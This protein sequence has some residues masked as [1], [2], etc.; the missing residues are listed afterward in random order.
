MNSEAVHRFLEETIKTGPTGCAL[1]VSRA[2]TVLYRGFHGFMDRE[3]Q[4]PVTPDTIYRIYS[5]TK[6]ITCTAAMMLYERGAFLLDE[7]LYNYLPEYREMQVCQY[8]SAQSMHL[9]PAKMPIRIR[10]LFCMTSGFTYYGE[11]SETQR[12][13]AKVYADCK[14]QR[15]NL[16]ET[17]RRL[18][19][20]PLAFEPGSRWYYGV[21]HDILGALIEVL[22][23]KTLAQ[24][25]Q[26][27]I[28]T[29]LGMENT[30]F[31][32]PAEK[33]Q[34]L[35]GMYETQPDGSL[36]PHTT[37]HDYY[38]EKDV[39][40][41]GG[42]GL[43]STL[44]DYTRFTEALAR[45][46]KTGQRL[47]SPNT[48]ALMAANHLTGQALRDYQTGSVRSGY[49][50]GLGVRVMTDPVLGG[51]NGTAGEFGWGGLAGTWMLVDPARALSAVYMHQLVP[52]RGD[53]IH[54][55]LRAMI[56]A[57]L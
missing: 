17:V 50:Y 54:P 45:G 10:D 16:R 44:E 20:V 18:S 42:A 53:E 1:Q 35:C 32:L 31:R 52:N 24:F 40:E 26:D 15:A 11:D 5:M 3:K 6:V 21:S 4:N 23:G 2:G 27:E 46:E 57:M 8:D 29:P 38:E 19:R 7:P 12:Q 39:Y 34:Q 13:V 25:F 28:F 9:E 14:G 56:Y 41:S 51:C 55:R 36:L 30:S 43:L 47:L 37:W 49:G 22:S 48:R 33:R